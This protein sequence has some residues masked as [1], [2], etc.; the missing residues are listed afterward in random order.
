MNEEFLVDPKGFKNN[1]IHFLKSL[2]DFYGFSGGPYDRASKLMTKCMSYSFYKMLSKFGKEISD[3]LIKEKKNISISTIQR[4][5]SEL[6]DSNILSCLGAGTICLYCA[7]KKKILIEYPD[8]LT[9]D[10]IETI[11]NEIVN[12]SLINRKAIYWMFRSSIRPLI[13]GA[14][15]L[16]W[17]YVYLD[18]L[19]HNI[20]TKNG[21][22][23]ISEIIPR[24]WDFIGIIK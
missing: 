16:I 2:R 12:T 15:I 1:V 21:S 4:V 6:S 18:V 5:E 11:N 9:K 24:E 17:F 22:K 19:K 20:S 7:K 3:E 23:D 10:I 13:K 8:F 14:L